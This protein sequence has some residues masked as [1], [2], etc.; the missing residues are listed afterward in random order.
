M[1]HTFGIGKKQKKTE[2]M[3]LNCAAKSLILVII[4]I[5]LNR[6]GKEFIQRNISIPEKREKLG[7][8]LQDNKTVKTI[9]I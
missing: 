8:A 3:F 7:D 2:T 6:N 1:K 9:N 5:L 4:F